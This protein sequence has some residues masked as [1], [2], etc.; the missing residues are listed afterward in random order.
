M[1]DGAFDIAENKKY[2]G[3]Q[4][5]LASMVCN[6]F[7]KKSASFARSE[8]SATQNKSISGGGIKN[9][10]ISNKELNEELHKPII[11]KF[12]KRKKYLC[13]V[14][15]VWGTDLA[16]MQLIS[17][18]IKGICFLLYVRDRTLSM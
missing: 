13:F 15:N 18:F 17:T 8:T 2:D 1:Y 14:D 16:N 11:R 10:N 3:Y 12:K 5:G 7:D 9:E 6:C 4:R